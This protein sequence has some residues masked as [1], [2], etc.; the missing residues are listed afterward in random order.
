VATE[1]S[2]HSISDPQYQIVFT[3]LKVPTQKH[4]T[5]EIKVIEAIQNREVIQEQISCFLPKSTILKFIQ[6]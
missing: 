5:A 6:I 2:K 4:P 1:D 3:V